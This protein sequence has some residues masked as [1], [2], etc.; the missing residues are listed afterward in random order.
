MKKYLFLFT[1]AIFIFSCTNLEEE[2]REDITGDVANELVEVSSLLNGA[3]EGL[4]LPYMDQSRFW[5]AQEHTGDA[6]MGPTRG[7][8]WDDNGIWRTKLYLIRLIY[9]NSSLLPN[10]RQKLVS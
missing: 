3:Y 7:P 5:A 8:D 9:Y 2:I 6:A 10:K 4:R 1:L